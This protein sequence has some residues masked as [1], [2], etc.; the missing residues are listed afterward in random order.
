MNEPAY[1]LRPLQIRGKNS[2]NGPGYCHFLMANR[3]IVVVQGY[4]EGVIPVST[5]LLR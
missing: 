2:I 4:I 1:V 3:V 5:T